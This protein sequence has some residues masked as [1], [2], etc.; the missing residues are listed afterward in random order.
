M[1]N[2]TTKLTSEQYKRT[3][4]ALTETCK[5]LEKAQAY[6]PQHQDAKYIAFLNQ[7]IAKLEAMLA[8]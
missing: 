5:Q 1:T 2:T 4:Q 3:L 8:A 7:H 6:L